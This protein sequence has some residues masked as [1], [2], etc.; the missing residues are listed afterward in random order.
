[1]S[2]INFYTKL[3][4]TKLPNPCYQAHMIDLPFR[5]L[6]CTA[7]GGGKTNFLINLISMMDK[8]F[9]SITVVTKEHEALYDML[10]EKIKN[11]K[12]H[13]YSETG[14]PPLDASSKK[15]SKLLV[16]DDLVLTKDPKIGESFIRARKLGY[17]LIYISQSYFGTPKIIRQ[18]VNYIALG[19]G[20]NIR[21]LRMILSE[22]SVD[23]NLDQLKDLYFQ[24]TKKPM[25][26]MLFDFVK[27][28]IRE[29]IDNV[30]FSSSE[31]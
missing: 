14:I 17:S 24:I 7:S 11:T 15:I 22:Y 29:N 23:L 2:L 3:K 1:M 28:N 18:N 26:F 16:Y 25:T 6:I 31:F 19:R 20:I 30:Q 9:A 4:D 13:L 21:D 27:N 12:I 8:T 10:A 5:M